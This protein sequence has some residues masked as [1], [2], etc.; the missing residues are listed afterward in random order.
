MYWQR[1]TCIPVIADCM[2]RDRFSKLR[3]HATVVDN[4]AFTDEQKAADRLWKVG[5]FVNRIQHACI[6]LP[7]EA[8]VSIDEQMIS[9]TGRCPARQ[10]VPRKPKPTGL[11]NFVLAGASGLVL[12]FELYQGA[13]TFDQYELNGKKTGQGT[14]AVLRLTETLTNGHRLF[15]DRFFTTP[16]LITHMSGRGIY[17]TGTTTKRNLPVTFM[18]DAAMGKKGCGTSEQFVCGN[19]DVSF[20]K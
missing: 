11:K 6:G 15:C 19:S 10:Y 20:V 1:T 18:T 14:G 16:P 13:G 4:N 2:H 12:D 5:P 9:F 7:R 3:N 8:N 17:M